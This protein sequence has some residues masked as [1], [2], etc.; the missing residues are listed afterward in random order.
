MFIRGVAVALFVSIGTIF[1]IVLFF[2]FRLFDDCPH[3][4]FRDE[5]VIRSEAKDRVQVICQFRT[6]VGRDVATVFGQQ[7]HIHFPECLQNFTTGEFSAQ[8]FSQQSVYQKTDVTGQKVS[9][10]AVFPS[11]KNGPCFEFCFHDP[12]VFFDPPAASVDVDDF[13]DISFRVG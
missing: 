8:F 10:Y 9:F 6:F 11:Y 7:C 4:C 1:E 5:F 13:T 2:L 3:I 12:E